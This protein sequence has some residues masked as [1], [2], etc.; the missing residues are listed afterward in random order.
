MINTLLNNQING[1]I[2]SFF[3]TW[4]SII[5]GEDN[6][7]NACSCTL[8]SRSYSSSFQEVISTTNKI[9]RKNARCMYSKIQINEGPEPLLRR[10][11]SITQKTFQD[12]DYRKLSFPKVVFLDYDNTLVDSWPQDFETSNEVFKRLSHPPMS[13]IEMLQEPHTP[14]VMAIAQRTNCSFEVVKKVY[15]EVYKDIHKE[16]APPLP[17]AEDLLKYLKR[18]KIWTAI[19]SNK[20]DDLLEDTLKKI[21]WIHYVNVY[22]GAKKGKAHKPDPLVVDSILEEYHLNVSRDQVFFVGDAVST[23]ILCAIN[24]RVIPIWLSQYSVDELRM[25][26]TGP[27]VLRTQNCLTFRSILDSLKADITII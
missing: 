4:I 1:F 26:D 20:E 13:V 27:Q 24:A 14:A 21:G 5:L 15:N 17:G 8:L 6:Q 19:V 7:G 3:L 10:V 2:I 18:N 25:G 12:V 9:F 11:K 22:K 23:D 16:L